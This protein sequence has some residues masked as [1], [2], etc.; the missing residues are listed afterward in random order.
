MIANF[1]TCM[2]GLVGNPQQTRGTILI[3]IWEHKQSQAVAGLEARETMVCATSNAGVVFSGAV[4]NG[5]IGV[6]QPAIHIMSRPV[7]Q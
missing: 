3:V 2:Q 6:W 4:L 1:M 5:W 7:R